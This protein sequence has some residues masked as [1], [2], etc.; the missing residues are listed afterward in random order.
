MD[1]EIHGHELGWNR[2][3]HCI[4]IFRSFMPELKVSKQQLKQLELKGDT[5]L[6]ADFS[7]TINAVRLF[8]N[9]HVTES[10]TALQ[11]RYGS[12]LIHTHGTTVLA[13]LK[14]LMTVTW[15]HIV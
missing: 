12:S 14:G 6:E 4:R 7:D 8:I 3:T 1:K 9:S 11:A 13:V 15:I 10:E 2:R 5:D